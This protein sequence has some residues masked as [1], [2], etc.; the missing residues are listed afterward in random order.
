MWLLYCIQWLHVFCGIFWFG[1]A[2]YGNV[3]VLPAIATLPLPQQRQI[4]KP[5]GERGNKVFLP[6]H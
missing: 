6:R 1:G 4:A 3:V 5:L 2:L